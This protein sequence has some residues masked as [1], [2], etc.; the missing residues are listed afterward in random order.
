MPRSVADILLEKILNDDRLKNSKAFSG[1]YRDEPI[2]K[3]AS[4]MKSYVPEKIREMRKIT[5]SPYSLRFY[6]QAAF[7]E[8]Y[9]DDYVYSGFF[10]SYYPTYA[11]M[12]NEQLR[13]Y[14]SWRTKVRR[15]ELQRT[16]RGYVFVYIYELLMLIGAADETEAYGKILEFAEKYREIDSVLDVYIYKW[17]DDF[18]VYYNMDRSYISA[19]EEAR[20][21][22][23]PAMLHMDTTEDSALFEAAAN[24]S[25]YN[26]LR[27]RLFKHNPEDT[28]AAVCAVLRAYNSYYNAHRKKTFFE[29]LFGSIAEYP[30]S[31]FDSAVFYDR[32][33][34]EYYEYT[35]SEC[36][37]YKCVGGYWYKISLGGSP[38][39]KRL[40]EILRA[41]DFC[42]RER[43]AITPQIK[44]VEVSKQT[45]GII[46]KELDRLAEEKRK[47][48][49]KVIDLDLSKLSDIRRSA[50]ITRDR[51][52]T[53][54]DMAESENAFENAVANSLENIT[55]EDSERAAAAASAKENFSGNFPK[56]SPESSDSFGLT[57]T[58]K[59][60]LG[61]LLS[62][63][64]PL[65]F[66]SEKALMLSV[67]CEAINEKLFDEIGDTV[68]DF[69]GEKPCITP[70]YIDD[71][72]GTIL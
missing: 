15:G 30:V 12:N 27:S 13:G 28:K 57:A 17:L 43:L 56:K 26:I 61:V 40:G 24:L 5:A 34:Y 64:D 63:G 47:N 71:V 16:S 22:Y 58:E 53:E 8:N 18:A 32:R 4:S 45:R 72:K 10:N 9:E 6:K 42:L 41:V 60:L 54:E 31:M 48:T 7:M 69:E 70:D 3:K 21:E 1:V 68:I 62:G 37:S 23:L 14:F 67:I 35:V 50:E 33:K 36:L 20:A 19:D 39:S 11:D 25:S 38:K 2:I 52:M 65:K 49:P 55:G 29:H 51:L 44:E 46:E 66:A 59:E